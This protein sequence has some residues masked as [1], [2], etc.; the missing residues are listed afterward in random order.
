MSTNFADLPLAEELSEIPTDDLIPDNEVIGSEDV[1]ACTTCGTA[2]HRPAGTSPTGRKLRIPKYCAD[3]K[4][5]PVRKT[6][7]GKAVR[8]SRSTVDIEE[9]MTGIYTTIGLIALAKD[10]ELGVTIIGQKRL[11]EMMQA[12]EE[13]PD[14]SVASAAGRAWAGVAAAN[15]KVHDTLTKMLA[16]SVWTE[17]LAA[18]MPLVGLAVQRKPNSLGKIK[19]RIMRRRLRKASENG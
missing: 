19:A 10:Q 11:A 4:T 12:G 13:N 6:S 14:T 3:C 15:P 1:G 5:T 9:G 16:T 7:S 18:H 8:R 2:V 17:I